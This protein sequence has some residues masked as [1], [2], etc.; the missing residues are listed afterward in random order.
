MNRAALIATMALLLAACGADGPPLRPE[1][2]TTITLGKGGISTQTGVS[3]QSGPV[4]VG[5]RL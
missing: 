2:E 4:T 3:V 1:V 5:V